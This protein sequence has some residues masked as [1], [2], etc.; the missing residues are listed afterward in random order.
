M[1]QDTPQ[2]K[3]NYFERWAARLTIMAVIIALFSMIGYNT[4]HI[5]TGFVMTCC[6]YFVFDGITYLVRLY[7]KR[8]NK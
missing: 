5:L 1:T 3:P 4:P 8:K 7:G 6:T 2:F